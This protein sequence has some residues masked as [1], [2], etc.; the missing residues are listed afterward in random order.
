MEEQRKGYKY[1][2]L[3]N[4]SIR[5]NVNAIENQSE[6]GTK[7]LKRAIRAKRAKA[8]GKSRLVLII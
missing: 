4:F 7:S 1:P 2:L 3:G 5:L 8:Q 6:L